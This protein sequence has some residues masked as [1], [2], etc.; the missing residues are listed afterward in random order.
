[1]TA[2][3]LVPGFKGSSPGHWQRVWLDTDPDAVLVEQ[4]DWCAPDLGRWSERLKAH[5]L[6]FPQST[7]VAHS[8]GVTLTVHLALQE[9]DI[10]IARALLVAPADVD[11]RVR[12]HPCFASFV[13]TP[14]E[15][16]PFPAVVVA[17]RN[18]PY[19]AFDRASDYARDWGADLYDIGRAGHINIESGY[20]YW[21]EA[22][23]LLPD[24]PVPRPNPA[25]F[26]AGIA[27]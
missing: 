24:L 8:L 3:I 11:I 10:G 5:L 26:A 19:I 25:R 2:T 14:R 13:P 21:P 7:V 23:R 17:S 15:A 6:R 22:T 4:D 27:Y 18:D 16:L 9:P 1:M 20:G 12:D